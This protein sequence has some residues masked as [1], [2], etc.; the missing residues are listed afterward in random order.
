MRAQW[1]TL[2]VKLRSSLSE[3]V[4]SRSPQLTQQGLSNTLWALQEILRLYDFSDPETEKQQAATTRQL[5]DDWPDQVWVGFHLLRVHR[6]S[7]A[8]ASVRP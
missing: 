1:S 8:A 6:T 5:I 4:V 3:A 2:D 7:T